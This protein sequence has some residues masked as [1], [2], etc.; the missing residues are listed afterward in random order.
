MQVRLTKKE[1]HL[2]V[3]MF[4]AFKI[5]AVGDKEYYPHKV[6][7]LFNFLRGES[8]KEELVAFADMMI[9]K[10]TEALK[11]EETIVLS[12]VSRIESRNF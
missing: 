12:V 11:K 10:S 2:V 4:E 6:L 5:P 3:K 7:Q 9:E 8:D 1:T